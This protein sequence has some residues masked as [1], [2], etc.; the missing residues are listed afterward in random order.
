MILSNELRTRAE[1]ATRGVRANRPG[2]PALD[3]QLGRV[4]DATGPCTVCRDTCGGGHD[5]RPT[6]R[7]I[8]VRGS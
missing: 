1:A 2:E 7:S 5:A 6:T 3:D 4:G 8:N